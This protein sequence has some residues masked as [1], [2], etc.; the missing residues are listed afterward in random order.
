MNRENFRMPGAVLGAV[1]TNEDAG[2][3]VF[4]GR[5]IVW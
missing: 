4:I 5:E 2:S 3:W 1:K